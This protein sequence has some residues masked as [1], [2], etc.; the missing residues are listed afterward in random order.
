MS[1][2]SGVIVALISGIAALLFV[3][4]LVSYIMKKDQGNEKMQKISK[5]VQLGAKAFLK[6][7]YKYV[8][9]F[10]IVIAVLITIAPFVWASVFPDRPPIELGLHT[11]ICFIVGGLV[12]ACAGYIGMSIATRSNARTTEAARTKGISGALDVAISGGAVM[13]MTVVG[14]SLTGLAILWLLYRDPVAVN[15]YA[16]GASLVSLFAHSGGGIFTKGADMGADLVGK[17][18]AGIP[19]DDPRNPAVI[20]DNVGDN[21]GDVAGLGADL[22]ESYVE[23]IIATIAIAFSLWKLPKAVPAVESVLGEAIGAAQTYIT[24]E[25]FTQ[26]MLIPFLIAAAGIFCSIIGIMYVKMSGGN[27]PQ[28]KLMNGTYIAAVLTVVLSYIIVKK[29]GVPFEDQ[30][31][32]YGVMGPFWANLAGIVSGIIVGFTSEYFTS[33]HYRPVQKLAESSQSGPAITVTGG[34]AVG[35]MSTAIPTI[36]LAA[37]IILSYKLSGMYGV[38]LAALGMLATTGMIVSVDSYGPIADN[39]GGMAEMAGLDKSVRAITDNLDAVGNTTAAIGKGFAIGSAAFAALSLVAAFIGATRLTNVELTNPQVMAGLL[40]GAMLPFLFCSLLFGAVSK[41]AFQM[42]AE[43]RRQ[44]REIKGLMEG[45]ADPD[46]TTC[47]DISTR[48]AIKGMLL[49]GTIAILAPV[50]AGIVLG[51]KGLSG[52]L[53][54]AVAIGLMLGIQMANSGGAMDNGKKYIEAGHFGG[55]GSDA[56]KAAVVGDTVGDPLKDTVGPSVNIL[57][58]LMAVISLVLAPLFVVL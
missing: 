37:A 46:P 31:G 36:I 26:L 43:V 6:T 38:A 24:G 48:S 22:L 29:V 1:G 3:L 8:F 58:K 27:N 10:V 44:F 16:M 32:S 39:A 14:L 23:A 17:V 45:K 33:G 18:E 9:S 15:G 57:I 49:P 53:V 54:G 50:V 52:M 30:F 42:I 51:P 35:M 11:A 47:V 12:S 5:M 7:E 2:D 34:M 41:C 40:I 20:A 55:K 19:E 13:G 25:Q 4:Y 56:H 21:V 28:A